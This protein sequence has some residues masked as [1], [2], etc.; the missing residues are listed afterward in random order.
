MIANIL[1]YFLKNIYNIL[2]K[3]NSYGNFEIIF[4]HRIYFDV[5]LLRGG[6]ER[7]L[8]IMAQGWSL[9]GRFQ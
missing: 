4:Q 8:R 5:Y 1:T 2:A 3:G 7:G 6:V 9:A